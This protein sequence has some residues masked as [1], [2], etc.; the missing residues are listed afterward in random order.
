MK[1]ILITNRCT[2]TRIQT[3]DGH[4]IQAFS[5]FYSHP[6]MVK[7]DWWHLLKVGSEKVMIDEDTMVIMK[8]ME[9]EWGY[10]AKS[11]VILTCKLTSTIADEDERMKQWNKLYTFSMGVKKD[12]DGANVVDDLSKQLEHTTISDKDSDSGDSSATT[13]SIPATLK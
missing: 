11:D 8:D 5:A 7:E 4:I 9:C 10:K 3:K 13:E 2:K 12:I 6:A 1:S